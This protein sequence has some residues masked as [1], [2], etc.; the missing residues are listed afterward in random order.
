MSWTW[1]ERLIATLKPDDVVLGGG[2]VKKLKKLPRGCRSG[3]TA[4]AFIGGFRLLAHADAGDDLLRRPV[5]RERE[6]ANAH[7]TK[8][9]D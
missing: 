7:E 1:M 5:P 3:D 6:S 4:N 9:I 8:P 2:N